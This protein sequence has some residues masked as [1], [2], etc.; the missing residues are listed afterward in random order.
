MQW[1]REYIV[2]APDEING[3]FAFLKVPPGEPFPAQL[4]ARTVCGVVWCYSG[5]AETVEV[6]LGPVRRVAGGPLLDL[7]GAMP[8]PS[9]QTMFDPLLPPGLQWYWRADWVN[10][11]S[12][13]AI[14]TH[15]HYANTIPTLLSA[16][17]LYPIN[18]VAG[19]VG[20]SETA[21]SYRGSTWGQVIIGLHPDPAN[22]QLVTDWAVEYWEALHPFSAGGA[23]VNMMMNEGA[24]RVRAAYP[25]NYDRL[26]SV[27]HRY[28]PT[29]LF[30][31]NQNI[32]PDK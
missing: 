27:K 21:F 29:N 9:L 11:L 26:V 12:D 30:H 14:D 6:M 3:F 7:V 32:K 4:H 28:D 19:R 15:L 2:T 10:E 22:A 20:A 24:Q 16:M 25:G 23:Y 8:Y 17:H 1:Y 18:G 5:P 31:V 13:A